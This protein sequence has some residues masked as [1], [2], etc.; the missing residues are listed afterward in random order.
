[1]GKNNP[2]LPNDNE[3]TKKNQNQ[4][5]VAQ[6]M[7]FLKNVFKKKTTQV[8]T[9]YTFTPSPFT[10]HHYTLYLDFVYYTF[11]YLK[12]DIEISLLT[13]IFAPRDI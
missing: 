12:E 2:R 8:F 10:H 11:L 13:H 5:S 6:K 1:L 4:L 7:R 3:S 9:I